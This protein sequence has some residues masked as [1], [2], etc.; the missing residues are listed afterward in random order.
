VGGSVSLGGTL[1]VVNMTDPG[2]PLLVNPANIFIL[3]GGGFITG[4]FSGIDWL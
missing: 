4:D 1:Q 3:F 2:T